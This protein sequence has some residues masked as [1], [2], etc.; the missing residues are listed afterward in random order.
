MEKE[1]RERNGCI[2]FWLWIAIIANIALS[3]FYAVS[4]FNV[5]TGEMALGFGLCSI[6]GVVNVLSAILLLR[7]NKVGFYIINSSLIF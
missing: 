7:W 5:G 3:I 4:M 6:F 1:I 2:S